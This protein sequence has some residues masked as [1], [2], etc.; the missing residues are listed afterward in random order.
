MQ[1]SSN[2]IRLYTIENIVDA[3]RTTAKKVDLSQPVAFAGV[4]AS[5]RGPGVACLSPTGILH[6][7]PC[8]CHSFQ[9]FTLRTFPPRVRKAWQISAA[10][11][12][13]PVHVVFARLSGPV[14]GV[15]RSSRALSGHLK[16]VF[17]RVTDGAQLMLPVDKAGASGAVLTDADVLRN[18]TSVGVCVAR[19]GAAALPRAAGRADFSMGMEART[20]AAPPGSRCCP[21]RA[22]GHGA[23]LVV[24]PE[25]L[26]ELRQ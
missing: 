17:G 6:V 20:G 3:D 10:A 7:S 14:K 18:A 24:M 23:C 22:A 5:Q 25:D 26:S 2:H 12:A 21:R 11:L 8:N 19:A 4:F 15:R 1:A 9:L 13:V 16:Q